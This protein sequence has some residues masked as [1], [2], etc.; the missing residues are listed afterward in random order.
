M[1]GIVA[2]KFFHLTELI[3]KS[4][5][6]CQV[7]HF[8]IVLYRDLHGSELW[9]CLLGLPLIYSQWLKYSDHELQSVC[10]CVCVCVFT[11]YT[12]SMCV[13]GQITAMNI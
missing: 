10:V 11:S 5:Y 9:H 8:Q 4:V 1:R 3:V 6:K 7:I 2:L 13:A 12:H